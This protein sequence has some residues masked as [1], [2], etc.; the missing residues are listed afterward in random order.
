MLYR[1]EGR[2]TGAYAALLES[3]FAPPG[4]MLPEEYR[5]YLRAVYR[6]DPALFYS[7]A[8]WAHE[9]D[10]TLT[11]PGALVEVLYDALVKVGLVNGWNVA[12]EREAV[13]RPEAT[14]G[15]GYANALDL[16]EPAVP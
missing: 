6:R 14:A 16:Y 13:A 10:L 8:R 11:G 2:P 4:E 5:G 1:T 7:W 15:V 12:T 3:P 9:R